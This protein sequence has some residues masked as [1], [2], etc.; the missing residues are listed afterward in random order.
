VS[1][2]EL[3]RF[4]RARRQ[5]LQ[6]ADVG[7]APGLRRRTPG[8]RRTEIAL[9]ADV[10]VDYYTRLEQARDTSPS[11]S[12]LAGLA[13]AL[14]LSTDERE[15]L[16]RI[17]GYPPP[18]PTDVSSYVEPAMMYLLDALTSVPA[19][20]VD[21]LTTVLA[22]NPLSRALVGSWTDAGGRLANVTW[23]WFTDPRSR[24]LNVP[25]EHEAIGR[26][27]VADLRTTA[28]RRGNDRVVEQL[29]G[30]LRAESAEFT[31][32]WE[33]MQ[34]APLQSTRKLLDHPQA[35]RLDV[36]CDFVVSTTSRQ[37]LVIF[38]PQPG[39]TTADQFDF[40]RVLGHQSFDAGGPAGPSGGAHTHR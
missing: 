8:L 27:Y 16:Y 12:I 9:L 17:A 28:A 20:V 14:R 21:D 1:S 23:R 32:Y 25:E 35:G 31:R 5:A 29:I 7:F 33:D 2:T 19:H 22:Q 36:Q 15:Y 40:L 39:S 3:G 4:L 11:E 24:A 30:D 26:G 13:R 38:R 34:V 37:R 18:A 10:S 6:P